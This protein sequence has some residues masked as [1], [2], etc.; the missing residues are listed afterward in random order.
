MFVFRNH[1]RI[2]LALRDRHRDDFLIEAA[3]GQRVGCLLLAANG[4]GVLILAGDLI[5][6]GDVITGLRHGI[7]AILRLH[8]RIDETP[9]DGRVVDFGVA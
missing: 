1:Q 5:I 4:E 9:A 6:D 8:Q 2:A 7:D 3:I